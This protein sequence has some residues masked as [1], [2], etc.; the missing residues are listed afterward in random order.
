MDG[1]FF[2]SENT[3]GNDPIW[4]DEHYLHP[5]AFI[6]DHRPNTPYGSFDAAD[7]ASL[8]G[9]AKDP[10]TTNPIRVD[11]YLDGPEGT[12]TFLGNEPVEPTGHARR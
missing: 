5:T 7:C 11:F 1:C 9:W 8:I 2:P 6:R 12:G 4:V 10:D 3:G